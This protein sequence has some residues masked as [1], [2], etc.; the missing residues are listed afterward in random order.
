MS[1]KTIYT[2]A[3]ISAK[4][5]ISTS[6]DAEYLTYFTSNSIIVGK[7][8]EINPVDFHEYDLLGEAIDNHP[9]GIN[10]M[11]LATGLFNFEVNQKKLKLNDDPSIYLEDVQILTA[12]N[13]IVNVT[14]F[15]LF[16]DQ[17]VGIIAGKVD[18][19]KILEQKN[20]FKIV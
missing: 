10:T 1:I 5:A 15:V 7:L 9:N 6:E 4:S 2:K 11:D 18:L 19:E 3:L 8:G 14:E 17:I 16:S 20:S 13:R 12:Q